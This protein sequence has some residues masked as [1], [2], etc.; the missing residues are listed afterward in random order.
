MR[1]EVSVFSIR[2]H[3]VEIFCPPM[4][5]CMIICFPS[6]RTGWLHTRSIVF[7]Q[8]WLSSVISI[9]ICAF[10]HRPAPWFNSFNLQLSH[11]LGSTKRKENNGRGL[12][13]LPLNSL[14]TISALLRFLRFS[15]RLMT[16]ERIYMKGWMEERP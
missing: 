14:Y 10:T 5:R 2:I 8:S 12:R 7:C 11:S 3:G 9:E 6:Y 15:K 13:S 4:A 16:R 1:F